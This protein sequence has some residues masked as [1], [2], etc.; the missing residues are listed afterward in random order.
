VREV[1]LGIRNPIE[2]LE[3]ELPFDNFSQMRQEVKVFNPVD[4]SLDVS[5][6]PLTLDGL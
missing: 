2:V 6:H 3:L 4:Q 5:S 1:G